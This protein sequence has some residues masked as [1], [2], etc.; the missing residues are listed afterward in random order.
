MNN[1]NTADF[2]CFG[3]YLASVRKYFTGDSVDGRLAALRGKTAL[4]EGTDSTG[5]F[6]VPAE[7]SRQII[8]AAMEGAIVRPLCRNIVPMSTDKVDIPVVVDADRSSSMFGGVT[9]SKV[10]E[11][12]DMGGTIVTPALGHLGLTAHDTECM[13]FVSNRL[14][15]DAPNFGAYMQRLF[16]AALRFYWDHRYIWGTGVGEPLGVMESGA[17]LSV[18]R[19]TNAGAPKAGDLA[20]MISRLLPGAINSAVWLVSQNVL[21]DWG[22]DTTSGSN[23]FG[24]ID[25][26]GMTAFGRPIIV[27]EKCAASGTTGDVI[28]ADFAGGYAIG[29]RG[30]E[31]SMSREVNYSSGTNGWLKNESCWRFIVRGDGQPILSAAITP[32]LGGE[33]LSHFVTLTTA[34]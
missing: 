16:S 6:T 12:D 23:A 25:L 14:E 33:T 13:A 7:F 3:E 19:A 18:A 26:S 2:S 31:I 9:V 4:A 5:G 29:E 34:S 11:A 8:T 15:A 10:E 27:T 32:Y 20:K 17:M 1:I 22:N 21:A 30:F 28:L 24:A